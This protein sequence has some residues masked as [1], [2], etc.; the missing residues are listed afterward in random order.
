MIVR[1]RTFD[2]GYARMAVDMTRPA[3]RRDGGDK[4][5]RVQNATVFGL[6]SDCGPAA[7]RSGPLSCN[8]DQHRLLNPLG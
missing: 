4:E 8:N 7:G 3:S 1:W 5:R 6:E 2:G